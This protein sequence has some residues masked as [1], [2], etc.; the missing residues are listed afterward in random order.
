M[1]KWFNKLKN[2]L[3]DSWY[4]FVDLASVNQKRSFLYAG[5]LLAF[6]TIAT[7]VMILIQPNIRRQEIENLVYPDIQSNK[8][9][10]FDEGDPDKVIKESKAISVMYGKP[11]GQTYDKVLQVLN[12]PTAVKDL[13]RTFYFYPIIYKSHQLEEKYSI[14]SNQ[15][16]FVFY[17]K[18]VEKNRFAVE[19]LEDFKNEF[20]P[21]LN[22]LPMWNITDVPSK[23]NETTDSSSKTV[24]DSSQ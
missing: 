22:R 17:E 4:D 5:S 23:T 24:K 3:V 7:L 11:D 10:F 21:E 18:G 1:E 9:K 19:N 14:D 15:I 8:V 2:K 6:V 13:N 16:T 12:N 20:V